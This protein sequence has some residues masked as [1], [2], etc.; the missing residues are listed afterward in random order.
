MLLFHKV[1][2]SLQADLLLAGFQ[3]V[4]LFSRVCPDPDSI[5]INAMF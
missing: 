5:H 1:E 4:G 3:M 2:M